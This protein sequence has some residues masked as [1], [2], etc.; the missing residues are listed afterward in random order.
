MSTGCS[1]ACLSLAVMHS[2]GQGYGNCMPQAHLV[3][4]LMLFFRSLSDWRL[5]CFAAAAAAVMWCHGW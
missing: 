3:F 1:G 4:S 2:F 5:F